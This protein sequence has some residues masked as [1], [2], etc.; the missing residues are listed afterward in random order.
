MG[1][2]VLVVILGRKRV[3]AVGSDLFLTALTLVDAGNR[4][5]ITR[6]INRL[7]PSVFS[8]DFH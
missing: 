8:I 5:L 3:P 6:V 1:P 4:N 2:V 7:P